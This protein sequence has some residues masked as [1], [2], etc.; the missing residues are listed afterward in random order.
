LE[1]SIKIKEKSLE[2]RKALYGEQHIDYGTS[3]MN[4]A[5]SLKKIG[6]LEEALENY[7]KA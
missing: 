6:R 2:I 5:V 1:E 4:L 3:L 7:L